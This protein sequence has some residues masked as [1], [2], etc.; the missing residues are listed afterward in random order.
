[1]GLL[2]ADR[3]QQCRSRGL[4]GERSNQPQAGQRVEGTE[5]GPQSF[6]PHRDGPVSLCCVG[7]LR[8]TPGLHQHNPST[9]RWTHKLLLCL[10]GVCGEPRPAAPPEAQQVHSPDGPLLRERV[11]VLSPETH[12]PPEPVEQN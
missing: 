2:I 10:P 3:K 7:A 5:H 11:Q 12:A 4:L 1:M 8:E 9:A 6:D